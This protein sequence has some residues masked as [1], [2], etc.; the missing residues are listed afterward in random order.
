LIKQGFAFGE[1]NRLA[2][3]CIEDVIFNIE[4]GMLNDKECMLRNSTFLIF[5]LQWFKRYGI[6]GKANIRIPVAG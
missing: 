2:T 6:F 1:K 5:L 3:D 4:Q